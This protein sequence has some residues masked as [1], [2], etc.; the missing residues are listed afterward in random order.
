[1]RT[2]KSDSGYEPVCFSDSHAA[3]ATF[4]AEPRSF[5]VVITDDVMPG[6]TGTGLATL[7]RRRRPDLPIVL[8]SGYIAPTLT[9]QG[10]AKPLQSRQI[11][12][13]LARLLHRPR[14]RSDTH[15]A[16]GAATL[17]QAIKSWPARVA[18][19]G[20]PGRQATVGSVFHSPLTTR[21]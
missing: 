10:L 21:R 20:P 19:D 8:V 14:G 15:L 18:Q 7:L 3:L 6:L 17:P 16:Q 9:R 12:A 2:R 13:T 11:A 4:E 5:D 1:M